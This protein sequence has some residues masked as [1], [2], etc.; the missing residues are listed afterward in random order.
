[1]KKRNESGND[2][3]TMRQPPQLPQIAEATSATTSTSR[4]AATPRTRTTPSP[5]TPRTTTKQRSMTQTPHHNLI[6]TNSW[7]K[8]RKAPAGKKS[9]TS[10]R[11][12]RSGIGQ[13]DT[14]FAT[15]FPPAKSPHHKCTYTDCHLDDHMLFKLASEKCNRQTCN[16]ELHHVCMIEYGAKVY[17]E[18]AERIGLKNLCKS[19]FAIEAQEKV[20]KMI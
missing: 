3:I 19:C 2:D 10:K 9:N 8:K 4:T 7:K 1:M 15:A 11:K 14:L 6:I 12:P 20:V 5:V 17:G 13:V 18:G 16:L